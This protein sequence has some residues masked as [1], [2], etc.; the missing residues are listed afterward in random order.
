MRST[1]DALLNPFRIPQYTKQF[2][3]YIRFPKD[4]D[5]LEHF[6]GL[7]LYNYSIQLLGSIPSESQF[8]SSAAFV[9]F[10]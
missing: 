1:G 3:K 5:I 8:V 6:Y 9:D 2:Q 7:Q 10:D 4:Y